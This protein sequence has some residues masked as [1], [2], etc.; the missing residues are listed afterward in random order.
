MVFSTSLLSVFLPINVSS[1]YTESGFKVGECFSEIHYTVASKENF[2]IGNHF[3]KLLH[4]LLK[5][6]VMNKNSK[7]CKLHLLQLQ[8]F[9]IGK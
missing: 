3:S 8:F 6:A 1:T 7:S 5:R 2:S 9:H 4:I